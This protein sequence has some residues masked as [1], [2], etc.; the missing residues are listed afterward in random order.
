MAI[1]AN[2][3]HVLRGIGSGD[4]GRTDRPDMV[5]LDE[6]FAMRTIEFP[7]VKATDHACGAMSANSGF[8]ESWAT[9]VVDHGSAPLLAFPKP[10]LHKAG[11]KIRLHNCFHLRYSGVANRACFAQTGL[12]G[13][14]GPLAD[15][16]DTRAPHQAGLNLVLQIGADDVGR[17][18]IGRNHGPVAAKALPKG[19]GSSIVWIPRA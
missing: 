12:E 16:S 2:D 14:E 11:I 5:D 17:I 7:K 9:F 15:L 10:F 6:A 4:S 1:G 18:P 3:R 19:E 13:K 8:T